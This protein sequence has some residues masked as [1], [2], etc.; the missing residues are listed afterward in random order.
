MRPTPG[1]TSAGR[2][3]LCTRPCHCTPAEP[4][5]TSAA[6]TSPPISACD[7]LE[8]KPSH[9]V[10]RFQTIAPISAAST[11]FSFA[12]LVSMIPLPT[13]V[14]T[15]V[16]TNAPARFAIAAT[17]TAMRGERARVET[18]VATAFA[19]SWNPLVKSKPRATT[20]TTT[21]SAV[22]TSAVLDDDRLEDVRGVLARVDGF[23]EPLVDVL[24]ADQCDRIR[25][26]GEELAD[27]VARDAVAFVLEL[28][29]LDELAAR[30]LEPV[31]L[32]DGVIQLLRRAQDDVRLLER[33]RA[34]AADAVADDVAR[35]LVDVVAD[36]V[37]RTGEPVDVV[38]VERRHEGP[39]EQVDD[40]MREPVA[41][42]LELLDRAQARFAV[43]RIR[44]EEPHEG[45]RDLDR[46]RRRAR[47]EVEELRSLWDQ[48]DANH[49]GWTFPQSV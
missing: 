23:L 29:Q 3:T 4:D 38:A 14:A 9:H 10:K 21:S 40:V 5:C 34:D 39:V 49:A 15:A 30:V 37:Q 11:V 46:V 8:G 24:P 36:I 18:D 41:F 12:R 17:A 42:V 31:Q 16:V 33:G 26:R 6:P 20:T 35:R 19:V 32:P 13:V 25:L 2:S 43:L 7:E 22:S 47:E 45:A 44:L 27:G 28:A 48:T 1:E